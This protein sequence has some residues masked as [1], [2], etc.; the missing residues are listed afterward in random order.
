MEVLRACRVQGRGRSR[1]LPFP[2]EAVMQQLKEIMLDSFFAIEP[3][4]I[5][6]MRA[7]EEL[8]P[9]LKTSIVTWALGLVLGGSAGH[10]DPA[11]QEISYWLR[12]QWPSPRD[13]ASTFLTH[14]LKDATRLPAFNTIGEDPAFGGLVAKLAVSLADPDAGVREK[15]REVIGQFLQILLCQQGLK[16]EKKRRSTIRWEEDPQ[17]PWRESYLHLTSVAEERRT[18]PGAGGAA[19]RKASPLKAFVHSTGNRRATL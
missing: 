1:T 7:V 19:W 18:F 4:F 5:L 13:R 6:A 10:E 8:S 11:Q 17:R 9:E 15:G 14:L 2:K 16:G 3:K 12:V